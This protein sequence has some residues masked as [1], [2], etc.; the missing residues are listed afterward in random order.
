MAERPTDAHGTALRAVL[1][2]SVL[3]PAVMREDLQALAQAGF[4]TGIWSPWIITELNRVLTWKWIRAAQGDL[5][6]AN[7]KACA[8]AAKRMMELLFATFEL[9]HPQPPYPPAWESLRDVWDQPIWA[10]AKVSQ[11]RYVVS[12]NTRHFPPLDHEGL[13]RHE[14]ITYLTGRAF[15][16]LLS[17]DT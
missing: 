13:R 1:D 7:E 3:V 16:S 15:V 11:A 6:L 14:G 17:G 2:T 5:S 4:Y 10:A 12:E 9:V 8:R